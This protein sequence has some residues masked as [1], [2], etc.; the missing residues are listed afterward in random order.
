[1]HWRKATEGANKKF[2]EAATAALRNIVVIHGT[3]SS[4]ALV[5]QLLVL[6][7][8]TTSLQYCTTTQHIVC[9]SYFTFGVKKEGMATEKHIHSFCNFARDGPR[10][11]YTVLRLVET[12]GNTCYRGSV[13]PSWLFHEDLYFLVLTLTGDN[14]TRLS[15]DT[16][17][18]RWF[19]TIHFYHLT[20]Q[21]DHQMLLS[22]VLAS[23]FSG[24]PTVCPRS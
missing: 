16:S 8:K 11:R 10:W 6:V 17:S 1:M 19:Q 21:E 14:G 9:F 4:S 12:Q 22:Q 18:P 7:G 13:I 3:R 24:T 2:K 5:A 20:L 23:K 15:S